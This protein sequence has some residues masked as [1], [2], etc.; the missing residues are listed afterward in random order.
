MTS[1]L[2]FKPPADFPS[3]RAFTGGAKT[4]GR[5]KALL[6]FLIDRQAD[7]SQVVSLLAWRDD[8]IILFLFI[9]LI[10]ILQVF[11]LFC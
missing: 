8:I 9:N 7:E 3:V 11:L 2:N 5:P 1:W 10:F 4:Q 6:I